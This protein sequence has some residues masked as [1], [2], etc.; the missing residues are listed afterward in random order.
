MQIS[1]HMHLYDPPLPLCAQCR[2]GGLIWLISSGMI[3]RLYTQFC[4][5]HKRGWLWKKIRSFSV[6]NQ[7]DLWTGPF[8][9][10]KYIKEHAWRACVR[11]CERA[12]VW[13]LYRAYG[14]LQWINLCFCAPV[15][16]ECVQWAT[17]NMWYLS[18]IYCV[19]LAPFYGFSPA[20]KLAHITIWTL[21][22]RVR[23][24]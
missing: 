21:M 22:L 3:M 11:L 9:S 17:V 24:S 13:F 10:D 7:G 1:F 5:T 23:R 18:Y 4:D 14:R 2:R 19:T 20:L 6:N 15:M 16:Y 8:G 12:Y